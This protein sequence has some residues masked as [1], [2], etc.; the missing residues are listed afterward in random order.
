MALLDRN[1]VYG[2]SRFHMEG[3]KR[4]VRAHI[5][6]EVAVRDMGQR[7]RPAAYLPHSAPGGTCAAAVARGV[8]YRLSKSLSSHHAVSSCAKAKGRRLG[9]HQ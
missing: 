1:G 6:A 2:A 5:G 4:G 8:P 3:Q 7:L 9:A